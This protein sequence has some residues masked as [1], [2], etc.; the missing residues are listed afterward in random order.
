V[1]VELNRWRKN[2]QAQFDGV[3]LGQ[4]VLRLLS[5]VSFLVRYSLGKAWEPAY[6]GILADLRLS[7]EYKEGRSPP[8][9]L[10]RSISTN[11]AAIWFH[12][13]TVW[14]TKPF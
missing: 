8:P 13:A 9:S 11:Q 10:N 1:S 3:V 7:A 2:F 4:P 5:G 12:L 14:A 6:H